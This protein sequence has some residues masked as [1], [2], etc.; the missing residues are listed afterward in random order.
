M[1]VS[2]RTRLL[3]GTVRR[4]QL[5]ASCHAPWLLHRNRIVEVAPVTGNRSTRNLCHCSAP[6]PSQNEHVGSAPPVTR[7]PCSDMAT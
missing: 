1:V 4:H 5:P 7:L 2:Q 6:L 3:V